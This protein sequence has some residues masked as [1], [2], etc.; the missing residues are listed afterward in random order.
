MWIISGITYDNYFEIVIVFSHR[1]VN[2]PNHDG[3]VLTLIVSWKENRIFI[4]AHS[5]LEGGIRFFDGTGSVFRLGGNQTKVGE[6]QIIYFTISL[7]FRWFI[8]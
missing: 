1:L 6:E 7:L 8:K 2:K 3:E 4:F 5:K